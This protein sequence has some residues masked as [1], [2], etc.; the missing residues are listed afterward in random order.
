MY[1][2]SKFQFFIHISIVVKLK[3]KIQN[4]KKGKKKDKSPNDAI[5]TPLMI[6]LLT[7][8]FTEFWRILTFKPE[9]WLNF[10]NFELWLN[11]SLETKILTQFLPFNKNFDSILTKFDLLTWKKN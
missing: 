5:K 11:L 3:N 7:V 9:F 10:L 2:V 4:F 6:S 1:I 8:I